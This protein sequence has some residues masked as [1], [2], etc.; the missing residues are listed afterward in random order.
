MAEC[1]SPRSVTA[2]NEAMTLSATVC[3]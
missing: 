2:V 1:R 3:E